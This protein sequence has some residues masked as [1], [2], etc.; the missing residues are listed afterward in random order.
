MIN[1]TQVINRQCEFQLSVDDRETLKYIIDYV[2]LETYGQFFRRTGLIWSKIDELLFELDSNKVIENPNQKNILCFKMDLI[3]IEYIYQICDKFTEFY[4]PET[5]DERRAY[6]RE[7]AD[8][9]NQ[10]M[11]EFEF[12]FAK[13]HDILMMSINQEYQKLF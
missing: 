7:T 11:H 13:V 1:I 3:Y 9:I 5:E 2:K 4:M 10:I 8:Y 12:D 6:A